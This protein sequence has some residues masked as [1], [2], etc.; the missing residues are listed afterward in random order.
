LISVENDMLPFHP[1]IITLL[2]PP[3]H[4]VDVD[5]TEGEADVYD[6]EDE[7]E[8]ENINDHVGHADDDGSCLPPHQPSLHH[9][10]SD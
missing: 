8:D 7:E 6:D 1:K 4:L 10:S 5:S 3:P 2:V 9:H